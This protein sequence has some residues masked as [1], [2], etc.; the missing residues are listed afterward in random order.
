[1]GCFCCC[2]NGDKVKDHHND[3]DFAELPQSKPKK[4]KTKIKKH[5]TKTHIYRWLVGELSAKQ[6]LSQI[7]FFFFIFIFAQ[8]RQ[9]NTIRIS[10]G[11]WQSVR[12]PTCYVCWYL[13]RFWCAGASSANMVSVFCFVLAMKPKMKWTKHIF[14]S[15]LFLLSL[16]RLIS[17]Q[18]RRLGPFA[19]ADRFQRPQMRRRQ[20]GS[21]QTVFAIL[22]S[23]A[24]HRSE[25]A[26]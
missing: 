7:V 17:L 15:Y 18:K 1:M 22:Q 13:W 26:D 24:L 3:I 25:N 20:R 16:S 4:Q 23:G 21:P 19:G 11:H 6:P 10:K 8:V 9:L 2:T 12:A 14:S 5:N